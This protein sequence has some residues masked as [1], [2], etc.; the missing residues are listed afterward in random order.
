MLP[1]TQNQEKLRAYQQPYTKR[2][3]KGD[4]ISLMQKITYNNL[5]VEYPSPPQK[6]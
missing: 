1:G 5:D 4:Q 3:I 2:K 6:T